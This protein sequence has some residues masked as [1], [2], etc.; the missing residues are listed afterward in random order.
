MR[1]I[2]AAESAAANVPLSLNAAFDGCIARSKRQSLHWRKLQPVPVDASVFSS[3]ISILNPIAAGLYII[4]EDSVLTFIDLR[5][6]A[7][8]IRSHTN[9]GNTLDA[10][11][12]VPRGNYP[13]Q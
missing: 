13:K 12:N 9:K 8:D 4:A 1:S 10:S 11:L 7:T 3:F 5:N 2:S 6:A